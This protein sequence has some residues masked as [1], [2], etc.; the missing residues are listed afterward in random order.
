MYRNDRVIPAFALLLSLVL[1]VVAYFDGR[2]I[3]NLKGH[4]LEKLS[5]GMVGLVA[6]GFV[7]LLFGVIGLLIVWLEGK[8]PRPM[9]R[10]ASPSPI[11]FVSII[12]TAIA[13][14]ATSGIFVQAILWSQSTRQNLP[15]QEGVLF[16]I[17]ALLVATVLSLYK[18]YF[19]DEEVKIESMDSEVPW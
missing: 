6:F 2:H 11:A 14:V 16:G 1:F 9:L 17:V 4:A 19:Q 13:L 18:R 15:L 10:R 3:A 7:L 5:S 12:V 8:E